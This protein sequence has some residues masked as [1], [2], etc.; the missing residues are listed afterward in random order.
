[1]KF[2]GHDGKKTKVLG[3]CATVEHANYM[4]EEFNKRLGKGK[5]ISLNGTDDDSER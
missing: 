2:Y 5:A 3:F 4:A 1:M